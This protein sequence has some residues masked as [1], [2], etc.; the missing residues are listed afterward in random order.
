[1]ICPQCNHDMTVVKGACWHYTE[2]G[3]PNVHLVNVTAYRCSHCDEQ[4]VDIPNMDGLHRV[5]AR[6]IAIQAARLQPAEIR[7][8]RST[9][10]LTEEQLAGVLAVETPEVREWEEGKARAGLAQ[11]RLL[12]ALVLGWVGVEP[13]DHFRLATTGLKD[14]PTEQHCLQLSGAF[15]AWV[16]AEREGSADCM[17]H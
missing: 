9:L 13:A 10:D 1:M 5:I 7:Y 3:L 4:A 8:L 2:S 17:P 11:E 14:D 6:D 12:R 16:T 15:L